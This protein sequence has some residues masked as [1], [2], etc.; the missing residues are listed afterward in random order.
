MEFAL[1]R[2]VDSKNGI[3]TEARNLVGYSREWR[4]NR[5]SWPEFPRYIP[6]DS[7]E[8]YECA[9][10]H[11]GIE[12][13]CYQVLANLERAEEANAPIKPE[14]SRNFALTSAFGSNMQ[15][16][17]LVIFVG[18]RWY[19]SCELGPALPIF[20]PFAGVSS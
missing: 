17:A 10:L 13:D 12:S 6:P 4:K 1:I 2:C 15:Q 8:D 7:Y 14:E 11:V 18:I 19:I 9:L 16:C 5:Q 20:S 3:L